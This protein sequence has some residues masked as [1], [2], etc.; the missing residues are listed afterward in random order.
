MSKNS[1]LKLKL[2]D[3]SING[4]ELRTL[5]SQEGWTLDRT[6]GSHEVWICGGR[7]FILATHSKDLKPYQVK[8]A[9]T[10]FSH[11]GGNDGKEK[12]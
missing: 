12:K 8:E 3:E 7:T 11:L 4:K 1:K 9:K 6:R 5:L 10:L 2:V